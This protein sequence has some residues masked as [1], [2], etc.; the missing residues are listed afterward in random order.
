MASA[1][2]AT[3]DPGSA[4]PA[5]RYRGRFAPSPTGLLHLGSLFAA[6]A[7]FLRARDCGGE[8][9]VRIEDIDPPR[10][11]AGAADA[12]LRQLEQAALH[13]DGAVL[14]QGDQFER[15]RET[16]DLLLGQDSAYRCSCSR[17]EIA[18]HPQSGPDGI[19]YPGTCRDRC[20]TA[21]RGTALRVRS[22]D[23][24]VIIDD[25]LQGDESIDINSTTGDIVIWRR[26]DLPAYHLAVVVDDARQGITEVVRGFDLFAASAPHIHLQRLLGLPVPA[27]AHLPVLVDGHG[28]KLSKQSHAAPVDPHEMSAAV[29]RCLDLLGWPIP[30]ELVGAPPS[31]LLTAAHGRIVWTTLHGCRQLAAQ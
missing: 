13:W 18:R 6:V 29:S 4:Q 8:W 9:L 31:E 15:Y 27:Y 22:P 3:A 11:I 25:A 21:S 2:T 20:L 17:R 24:A 5:P 30:A 26:D 16:A 14:R 1:T 10:E 19:R 23:A 7:S 12:I 28:E